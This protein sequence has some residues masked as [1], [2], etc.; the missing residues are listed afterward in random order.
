[1]F[2][3]GDGNLHPLICYDERIPGQSRQA[4]EVACGDP[5]Y[6]VDA[7][8]SLTGEHGIGAD[9]S[10]TCRDV[11]ADDLALMQRVALAFDPREPLQSRQ[12]SSHA[13]SVRRGPGP[14]RRHPAE[15]PA[16]PNAVRVSG[17]EAS[18]R[19]TVPTRGHR[20][21]PAVDR[22]RGGRG[23][24]ARLGR[25]RSMSSAAPDEDGLGRPAA[26][27]D[28]ML[29]MRRLNRV[30]THAHGDLTATVEA[31]ATL[32]DVNDT[33]SRLGQ[34]CRSIR[35]RGRGHHRRH[36]RHQRQRP[37]APPLRRAARL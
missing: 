29:D 33:L 32:R 5:R 16:S 17:A 7:G 15:E 11:L 6:C 3:A 12:E 21:R 34:G 26:R 28:V 31:G 24:E 2:H 37:A 19:R 27:I 22:R 1:V 14:Y 36:P 13:A 18:C 9:K 10:C 8:G 25:G 20:H 23:D 35:L 30:L 4:V